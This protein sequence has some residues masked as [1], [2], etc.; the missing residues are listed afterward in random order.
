MAFI[1]TE[2]LPL[3]YKYEFSSLEI[4]PFT[5][6]SLLDYIEG[7]PNSNSDLYLYDMKWLLK[8]NPLCGNLLVPDAEYL[9]FLKKA[10]SIDDDLIFKTS[11]KCPLCNKLNNLFIKGKD[12]HFTR[13]SDEVIYNG[14]WMELTTG[15]YLCKIPTV[16]K[17]LKVLELSRVYGLTKHI[18][19]IKSMAMINEQELNPMGVEKSI[20]EAKSDDIPAI[21]LVYNMLY[22]SLEPI[23]SECSNPECELHKSG[24]MPIEINSLIG[25]VFQSI[26]LSKPVDRNKVYLK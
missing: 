13:P 26:L 8:D 22:K 17:L 10:I 5:Y 3:K 4:K 15:T 19:L 11:V 23:K 16:N 1:N 12:L 2:N 20:L 25:N 6:K 18:D 24:G 9:I 14:V 7:K 21:L